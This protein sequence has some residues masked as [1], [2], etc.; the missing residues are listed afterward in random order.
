MANDTPEVK[1]PRD[2]T[3]DEIEAVIPKAIENRD[4]EVVV[5]LVRLLA[6]KDAHRAAAMYE[7][8]QLGIALNRAGR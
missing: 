1:D 5:A 2:W 3:P 8:L 7:T 6:T 4:F